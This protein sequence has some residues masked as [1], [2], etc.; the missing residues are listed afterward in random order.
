MSVRKNVSGVFPRPPVATVNSI[1][2]AY[3]RESGDRAYGRHPQTDLVAVIGLFRSR[4]SLTWG[5]DEIHTRINNTPA[6]VSVSK[7]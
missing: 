7:V 6:A 3:C 2:L 1:Q 5:G 4:V